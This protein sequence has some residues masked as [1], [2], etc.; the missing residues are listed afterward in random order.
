MSHP[1]PSSIPPSP[2]LEPQSAA[3]IKIQS[4]ES[5]YC[6]G[7]SYREG[8]WQAPS[9]WSEEG[10]NDEIMKDFSETSSVA[11]LTILLINTI[12]MPHFWNFLLFTCP[13]VPLCL[14]FSHF[15]S[16]FSQLLALWICHYCTHTYPLEFL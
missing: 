6:Q 8:P 9:S 12:I 16:R 1:L 3:T 13:H 10:F 2:A 5:G 4:P 14:N 7:Y 11:A 15:V